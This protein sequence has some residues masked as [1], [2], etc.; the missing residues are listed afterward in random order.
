MRLKKTTT[1]VAAVAMMTLAACG[2]GGGNGGDSGNNQAGDQPSFQEGGDRFSGKDAERTGPLEVPAEAQDGGTLTVLTSVAPHTLDPTRAYYTD[3]T[4]I[5]DLVTRALTQYVYDSETGDMV[6]IPDMA[7]GLGQPNEDNTEWTFT[8]KEGLKYEDGSDV[9][10][11]DVAYAVKRSFALEEL[12]DGPTYQTQFFLNGEQYKGPFKDGSDYAGV[13]VNGQDITI[14]MARPFPE[15]DYF[16][17]FPVFTAIP[18]EK[19]T[20]ENYGN[21]PLATGPYKFENYRPGTALTL[22]KNDQWDP[23]TDPGRIQAVDRW[24]FQFGEDQARTENIIINDNGAAQTTLTYDNITPSGLRAIQQEGDERLVTGTS[25][26]TYMW[27]LDT[28]KIT[29][30]DV[31]MAIGHAYPYQAAWKAAGVIQGVTR[32]PGTTI[33]P[34]GTAGRQEFDPLGNNGME[35]DTQKA[36]QLLEKAGEVGYEIRFLYSTDDPLSVQTKDVIAESL[37]EAGFKPTPVAATSATI[38]DELNDPNA[39]INVRSQ[40][41]CSDWPSG[42]SWFPAQ[43]LGSLI[44]DDSVTNPSFLDVPAVNQEINRILNE[45]SPEE[46]VNA[47]GELDKMIMTEHYPAVIT[48]YSGTAMLRGSKVGGMEPDSLRGM[49][50]FKSMYVIE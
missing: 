31:R 27:Y 9:K 20:V 28:R 26:C 40:G 24:E 22:V 41:W 19:D 37:R 14:K 8:L 17:S 33:L 10:P 38:R 34:P 29:N 13:E 35:T 16:A 44:T 46:A 7:E 32:E 36:R 30:K 18:E 25:P 39:N 48:G 23:A 4:A 3:S 5:L 1:A 21:H 50:T 15:M 45:L 43:W 42:G 12:P 2:G 6:L 11:E 49:P 47:W